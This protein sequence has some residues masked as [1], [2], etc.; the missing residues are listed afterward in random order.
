[1][2]IVKFQSASVIRKTL[3]YGLLIL[4]SACASTPEQHHQASTSS[5]SNADAFLNKA[6]SSQEPFSSQFRIEAANEYFNVKEYDKS[7]SAL[8]LVPKYDNLN[9][10]HQAKYIYLK[11]LTL[12][13]TK[14]DQA[15]SWFDKMTSDLLASLPEDDQWSWQKHYA[16]QLATSE[17]LTLA[18]DLLSHLEPILNT[19]QTAEFNQT[20]WQVLTDKPASLLSENIKES[21]SDVVNGWIELAMITNSQTAI[22]F[23]GIALARWQSKHPDHPALSNLPT[24]VKNIPQ[25]SNVNI[26]SIAVLLPLEGKFAS[27]SKS[28]VQ[29][30]LMA[31]YQL[32]EDI[33]PEI[34]IIN[35][36][37]D[38]FLDTYNAIESDLILGPLSNKNVKQLLTL[39]QLKHP[40][41]A[42]NSP[43]TTQLPTNLFFM[44]L[45]A[46]DEA[47]TMAK[48]AIKENKKTGAILT[49][50][51]NK[52]MKLASAFSQAFNNMGGKISHIQAY[53]GTW[54]NSLKKL[55]EIDKSNQRAQQL[56]RLLRS[57]I[58]FTARRRDDV[59]FIYS[60]LKYKDLRQTNPLMAFYFADSIQVY[61]NSDIASK[62]H[63]GKT[64]KDLNK[65]IFADS[66]WNPSS[67]SAASLLPTKDQ[68]RA[69]L[70][71]WGADIFATA[72]NLPSLLAMNNQ[73]IEAY[74]S[75]IYFDGKHQ[76]IREFPVSHVRYGK[77]YET[78]TPPITIN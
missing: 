67:Y 45:Q 40:T 52:G 2:D 30:I 34:Q 15:L 54:A 42:L 35:S 71:S 59:E 41:I 29:G 12:F 37:T 25:S 72:F 28:L 57:P 50:D 68:P 44:E 19:T 60:P 23:K 22:Q 38:N 31:N 14:S 17:Q 5:F 13:F 58:E 9:Q 11:S 73:Q 6:L 21:H 64:D 16:L 43:E 61:S 66:K 8:N 51:S 3:V 56:S 46:E 1:M 24:E 49:Y 47:R 69:K 27:V 26:R 33:R 63:S 18:I 62:L 55:L 76:F 36:N 7:L 65:V 10:Q 4:L 70:Y 48:F 53:E 20:I 77:P 32:P 74:S 39:P 75:N 78:A